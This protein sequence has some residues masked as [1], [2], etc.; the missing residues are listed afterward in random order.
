MDMVGPGKGS[1]VQTNDAPKVQPPDSRPETRL[2]IAA[3]NGTREAAAPQPSVNDA[4][5]EFVDSHPDMIA[6]VDENW[7]ILAISQGWTEEAAQHGYAD[8]RRGGDYL[9]ILKRGVSEGDLDAA[10]I[11]SAVQQ[12]ASGKRRL[13]QYVYTPSGISEDRRFK[14]SVTRFQSGGAPMAMLSRSEVTELFT[15]AER[16][17]RLESSLVAVQEEERRRIG[18]DL[19]D[20]TAQLL[21]ALQ[22][23]LIRLKDLHQDRPSK[24]AFREMDETLK[25]LHE[26]VRALSYLLHPPLLVN[27][28]LVESLEEMAT[29]FARRSRLSIDFRFD[30]VGESW[31]TAVEET[32]YRLAQEALA[33]VHRHAHAR[34]VTIRLVARRHGHLHLIVHDDGVGMP[35]GA[36]RSLA[37]LGVGIAGMRERIKEL[38]G[39][40]SVRHQAGT[41]LIASI[42]PAADRRETRQPSDPGCGFDWKAGAGSG[43]RTRVTS[44]EG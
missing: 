19:H 22:L 11:L 42:P 2:E 17:R 37:P 28:G 15:L 23:G 31:S 25:A 4:L 43:N 24:L 27:G 18:R 38:G 32:L 41:C 20:S 30:G 6:L 26:E 9:G 35:E 12:V 36:A 14:F 8:Y 21:V 39:R 10:V 40:F 16:C 1:Q 7:T 44:L 33:N 29:G 13:F 5:Q 34:H 3:T